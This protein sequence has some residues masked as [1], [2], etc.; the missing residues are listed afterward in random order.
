M[1]KSGYRR[2]K[3]HRD[4]D[5][6]RMVEIAESEKPLATFATLY[7]VAEKYGIVDLQKKTMEYAGGVLKSQDE[8]AGR[9]YSRSSFWTFFDTIPDYLVEK[10]ELTRRCLADIAGFAF[11]VDGRLTDKRMR[12]LL[13]ADKD[14]SIIINE[15][16]FSRYAQMDKTMDLTISSIKSR[17]RALNS[18]ESAIEDWVQ[19]KKEAPPE[20]IR[21]PTPPP[22]GWWTI[23]DS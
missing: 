23:L 15:Q 19:L 8:G 20:I 14:L 7:C 16:L 6:Q 2:G 5:A 18:I 13:D 10:D 17:E 21:A 4:W 3:F 22:S 9:E 12:D 1:L 11:D